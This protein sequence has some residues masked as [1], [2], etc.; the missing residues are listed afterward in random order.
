MQCGLTNRSCVKGRQHYNSLSLTNDCIEEIH[1]LSIPSIFL[2]FFYT[3]A[4]REEEEERQA[5]LAV[6]QN[7]SHNVKQRKAASNARGSN[8][9]KGMFITVYY[10]YVYLLEGLKY[11][12]KHDLL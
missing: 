1:L 7:K 6:F 11:L 9:R 8:H 4:E 3:F 2:L 10:M 12:I 5:V